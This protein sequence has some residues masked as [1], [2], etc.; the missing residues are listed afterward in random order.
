MSKMHLKSAKFII[1]LLLLLF[2][3]PSVHAGFLQFDKSVVTTTTGASFEIGV[4]VD[5]AADQISSTDAWILYDATLLE[6]ATVTQGTFFPTV[7]NI[8]DLGRIYIAGYVD[9]VATYKTGSGLLATVTFKALKDGTGTLAFDCQ[10]SASDK[11][12]IIENDI[13]ATNVIVCTQNTSASV[14]VGGGSVVVPTTA[15]PQTLPKTGILDNVAKF[16]VPGALLFVIGGIA[17]LML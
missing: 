16:A 6:A 9:D 14:T 13:N 2:F 7:T 3:V 11:S 4:N 8:I 15:L 12:K 1:F 10:E 17:K 5:A